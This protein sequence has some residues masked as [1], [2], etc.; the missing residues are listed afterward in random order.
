MTRI[1]IIRIKLK[2]LLSKVKR[3]IL[4]ILRVMDKK[5][6]YSDVWNK[7]KSDYFRDRNRGILFNREKRKTI[8]WR[9]KKGKGSFFDKQLWFFVKDRNPNSQEY[10]GETDFDMD[11]LKQITDAGEKQ[12][13]ID[14]EEF[15]KNF[16]S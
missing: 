5:W 4:H 6:L 8:K 16:K 9:D 2:Y 10:E 12:K 1:K 14:D 11:Y 15:F 13:K 7:E 3:N